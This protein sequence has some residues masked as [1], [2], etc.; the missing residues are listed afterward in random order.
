MLSL[1]SETEKIK[2]MPKIWIL[3]HKSTFLAGTVFI[4]T[5][6]HCCC[7]VAK[8]RLTLR[9]HELQH[10][11]LP[12]LHHLGVC[13]HS[14]LLSQWCHSTI[15]YSV[16][17]FSSCPP[18]FPALGSF[19]VIWLFA[20]GGQNIGASASVLPMNIQGWF[21]LGLTGLMS[22]LSKGLSR[23]FSSTTVWKH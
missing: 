11:R 5:T 3:T 6:N 17:P 8:S 15:S 7:S 1:G 12:V 20:S 19:P 2:Y 14:C 18:T 4:P 21:P 9:P 23:V 10:A 22:L 16:V 13:S